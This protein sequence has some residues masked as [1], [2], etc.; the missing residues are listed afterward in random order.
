MYTFVLNENVKQVLQADLTL[1]VA[2]YG[3]HQGYDSDIDALHN[4]DFVA[5][6]KEGEVELLGEAKR[7]V[8]RCERMFASPDQEKDLEIKKLNDKLLKLTEK[9]LKLTQEIQSLRDHVLSMEAAYY[10]N[11]D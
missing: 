8:L 3:L 6:S 2:F 1:L 4:P 7:L 5:R 10:D 9:N 11:Q